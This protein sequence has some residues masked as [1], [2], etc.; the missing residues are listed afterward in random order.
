MS[1]KIQDPEIHPRML[2]FQVSWWEDATFFS[3]SNFCR[4]QKN[5]PSTINDKPF[6]SPLVSQFWPIPN[7]WVKIEYLKGTNHMLPLQTTKICSP[8]DLVKYTHAPDPS[9]RME[10]PRK[11]WH[12]RR[13]RGSVF[14]G[15]PFNQHAIDASPIGGKYEPTHGWLQINGVARKVIN[16]IIVG[17]VLLYIIKSSAIGCTSNCESNSLLVW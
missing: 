8:L 7:I 13:H 6:L 4:G 11:P 17:I 5:R 14:G 10:L 12:S 15:V 16:G 3:R 1:L 9:L 2:E